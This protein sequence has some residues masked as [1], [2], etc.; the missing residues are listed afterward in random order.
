MIKDIISGEERSGISKGRRALLVTSARLALAAAALGTLNACAGQTADQLT[1]DVN[2]IVN[3]LNSIIPTLQG[4]PAS[5][6]PN[7]TVMAQIEKALQDLQANAAAVGTALAPNPSA[8][9]AIST[10]ISTLSALVSPF[11]PMASVLNTIIQAALALLPGILAMAKLPA[12]A[13]A[14]SAADR[15]PADAARLVLRKAAVAK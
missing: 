4:L 2:L 11:Y 12:P 14:A 10:A 7:A 3:G 1:S 8:I 15:M 9:Q 5:A 13:A 6:Q